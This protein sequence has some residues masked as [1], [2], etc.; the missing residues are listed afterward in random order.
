MLPASFLFIHAENLNAMYLM[1]CYILFILMIFDNVHVCQVMHGQQK[2]PGFEPQSARIFS[3]ARSHKHKRRSL[4]LWLLSTTAEST[5]LG[6]EMD[7]DYVKC[8]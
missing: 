5:G 6:M 8:L 7:K 4:Q 3:H 1:L 2:H